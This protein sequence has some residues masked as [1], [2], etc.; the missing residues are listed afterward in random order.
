[1][2]RV[3]VCAPHFVRYPLLADLCETLRER[4][5]EVVFSEC[6]PRLD[7]DELIDFLRGCDK[8]VTC[9]EIL[10]DSVFAAVPE[11]RL[12]SK[13]GVGL[14]MIDLEAMARHGV[15]LGWQGGINKRAVSELTLHFMIAV[16]RHVPAANREVLDGVWRRQTGR[17]L[18]DKTVGI[19]GCGHIGKDL[20]G[21]LKPFGCR[22]LAHDIRDYPE[23]YR[24]NGV[25]PVSL[26]ELLR[27]SDIVTLHV[28]LDALTRNILTAERLALMKPTACLINAARGGLLDE[29]ALAAM[30][31]DGRLAAAGLDVFAV[32]PPPDTEL[33]RLPNFL[34]TP[35]MGGSAEEAL[36]AIGIAAVVGLE[37]ARVPDAEWPTGG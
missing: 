14:D 32:E 33:L 13:V 1:M 29:G 25:E 5:D 31:K 11:M 21:L 22:V 18:T 20:T 26:E 17:Q 4:Y 27:R 15:E 3:A 12:V 28:P 9:L 19:I 37:A 8:A 6:V 35:H 24:D 16:L 2:T 30:L 7:G 34:A 23:F 10:D 36:M